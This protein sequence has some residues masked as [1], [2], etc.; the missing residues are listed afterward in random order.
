[1]AVSQTAAM[2]KHTSDLAAR[3]VPVLNLAVGQPDFPTPPHIKEAGKRA[4]DED[5]SYYSP[6]AGFTALREAIVT[7]MREDNGLDYE[8]GEVMVSNGGKHCIANALMSLI[9]ECDEVIVPAPYWVS[10][11]ELVRLAGGTSVVIEARFDDGYKITPEQLDGAMTSRTK[12]L[13]LCSPSNPTG[14]VYTLDELKRLAQVLEDWPGVFV[15][16]DEVYEYANFV[17]EHASMAQVV[18]MKDRCVVV[19]AVSKGFAMTGWRIGYMCAPWWLV[20]AS[21]KLQG[22][23]TTGPNSIAQ[24]AAVEALTASK[25]PSREMVHQYRRRRDLVMN[26][27]D[28]IPN[29]RFVVPDGAFYVF[30]DVSAFFGGSADGTTIADSVDL[31]FHLLENAGVAT[32]MGEAF[33]APDC[34]RISY[35]QSER[36][37]VHALEALRRCLDKIERA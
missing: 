4:I 34:I 25:E 22:Q 23:F 15:I 26:H 9:D 12:A 32:V 16:S 17:G 2:F 29:V 7:K 30:P 37:L 5:Y 36:T 1:M 6:V 18:G 20:D 31:V 33:G 19:N 8:V 27:L 21:T 3:G 24:M 14:A 10:Y 13:I 11:T 28:R 35:A